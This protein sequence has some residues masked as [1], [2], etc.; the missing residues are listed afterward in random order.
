MFKPEI[1][2][3]LCNWVMSC[4]TVSKYLPLTTHELMN[5]TAVADMSLCEFGEGGGEPNELTDIKWRSARTSV[6]DHS[7][8]NI[9]TRSRSCNC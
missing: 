3:P 9:C 1:H 4:V 5:R 2:F 8:C 7:A 6:H